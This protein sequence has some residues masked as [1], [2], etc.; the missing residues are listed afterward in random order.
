MPAKK[1]CQHLVDTESQC[2]SAA[3]R[4]VGQCPHCRAQFC[5]EHRMP[6]HHGCSNLEDC[7]KRAYDQNKE[8][9]EKERT[10]ASRMSTV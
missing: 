5:A 6:E 1:R 8:K 7:R 4:I 10:I 3:L 2:N 9:L